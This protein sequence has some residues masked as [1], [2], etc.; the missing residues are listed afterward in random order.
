MQK[1][2]TRSDSFIG[3]LCR[4][5]ESI[6][7]RCSQLLLSINK[8]KDLGLTK[9]LKE[10]YN[11]LIKRK[12]ILSRTVQSFNKEKFRDTLSIEFL[13]EISSRPIYQ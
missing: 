13:E 5:V 3:G 2:F 7:N 10:E 12:L 6:R 11:E 9:R 4:E 8:C 1:T